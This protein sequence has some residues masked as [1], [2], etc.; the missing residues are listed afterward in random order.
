MKKNREIYEKAKKLK[1]FQWQIAEKR[2][3]SD[4]S[5]YRSLRRELPDAEKE[6]ILKFI[7]KIAAEQKAEAELGDD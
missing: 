7:E 6:R 2:G 5:H 1:V 4:T 3:M